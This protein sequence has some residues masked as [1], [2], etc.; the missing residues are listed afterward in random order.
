MKIYWKIAAAALVLTAGAT[1]AIPA[2]AQSFGLGFGPRGGISFS[3]DSGGY[4]D[5]FGCPDDFWDMPV[6]YGPVFWHGQWYDGPVYYR[7]AFGHRQYWIHGDWRN[8]EW[9]GPHPDWWREGRYGPSLGV[10][11]YRNNGFHGRWDRGG[12]GFRDDRRDNNRGGFDRRDDGR[13]GFNQRDSNPGDGRGGFNQRDSN[14]GYGR[15]GNDQR[16]SNPGYGRGGF[17]QR[18]SN[19]GDGRGGFN[20]RDSNPGYGRGAND[21]RGSNPGDGRGG[22]RGDALDQRG[23]PTQPQQQQGRGPQPQAAP[24]RAAAPVAPPRGRPAFDF[25]APAPAGTPPAPDDRRRGH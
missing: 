9:R 25:N 17:N 7:S 14:P 13:G 23:G 2:S 24:A 6:F 11:Y 12:P 3:Y 20:Q 8:D 5:Q 19:P 1:A 10:D 15:G 21:Q 18:D 22:Y 16:G 4:C